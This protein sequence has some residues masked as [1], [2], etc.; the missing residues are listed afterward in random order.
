MEIN[1]TIAPDDNMR[2]PG[3]DPAYFAIGERALTLIKNELACHTET[4]TARI[5]DFPSGWG[6]VTRWL[7]AAFPDAEILVSD[8]LEDALAWN[9]ETFG[10]TAFE[11]N[12]DFSKIERQPDC[13]L[14]WV[15]SL[16]TH[17]PE[18]SAKAFLDF[19]LDCMAPNGLLM[20]TTHGRRAV[21]NGAT[22][23]YP[24]NAFKDLDAFQSVSDA[25]FRGEYA[26][27]D[28]V[29]TPGYGAA[30]IPAHWFLDQCYARDDVLVVNYREKAWNNHQDLI[31][32]Q[33]R[34]VAG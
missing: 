22:G 10:T 14:I 17:L 9:V 25:F 27:A 24:R 21:Y 28:Y 20:I 16:I 31:T 18:R 19:A 11:T 7:S 1:R 15:G 4:G 29:A 30:Y 8:V 34:S 3:Q 5:M 23:H 13:D 12:D 33:N 2:P 6:R 32:L 26:Y